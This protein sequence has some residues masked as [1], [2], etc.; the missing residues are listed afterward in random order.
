LLTFFSFLEEYNRNG[1]PIWGLTVQNEPGFGNNPNWRWQAM[2][3]SPESER[4]FIKNTLGPAL[5]NSPLGQKVALMI[6][7]D[8]RNEVTGWVNTVSRLLATF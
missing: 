1:V 2:Y 5:R 6:C 4:D 3:F 8:Q 7:D